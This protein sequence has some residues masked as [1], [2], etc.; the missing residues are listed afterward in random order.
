MPPRPT[1]AQRLDRVRRRCR[2]LVG[3]PSGAD[4][5]LRLL[6]ATSRRLTVTVNGSP[7]PRLNEL[8]YVKGSILANV[9][10]TPA[11]VRIDPATG[12]V[13]QIIDLSPVIADAHPTNP[14]AVPNGIAY[15][16]VKHRIFVTGK[17]WPELFEIKVPA[18]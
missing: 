1:R 5:D 2:D 4:G 11:V 15:D 18:R 6:S 9:W 16:R 12:R 8:E 17:N 7:L 13:T 10:M 3:R 14:D